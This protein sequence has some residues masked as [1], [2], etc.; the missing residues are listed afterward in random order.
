MH[1]DLLHKTDV[2]EKLKYIVSNNNT[3]KS[4]RER[5]IIWFNPPCSMNVR[6]NI[7]RTF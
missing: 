2:T 5:K 3:E 6:T 1:Q 7:G 4:R